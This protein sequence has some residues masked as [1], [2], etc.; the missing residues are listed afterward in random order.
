MLIQYYP[1]IY[2][3]SRGLDYNLWLSPPNVSQTAVDICRRSMADDLYGSSNKPKRV[4]VKTSEFLLWGVCLNNSFMT[5]LDPYYYT[6]AFDRPI[7]GF[8]GAYIPLPLTDDADYPQSLPLDFDKGHPFTQNMLF[9]PFV[10]PYWTVNLQ[11]ELNK[12]APMQKL[13]LDDQL[14]QTDNDFSLSFPREGFYRALAS[15]NDESLNRIIQRLIRSKENVGIVTGVENQNQARDLA[16]LFNI[17]F[18]ERINLFE[19][20][21][22]EIEPK[23]KPAPEP[24]LKPELEREPESYDDNF[25]DNEFDDENIRGNYKRPISPGYGTPSLSSRPFRRK[26]F[27]SDAS[28]LDNEVDSSDR[29]SIFRDKCDG[30]D[31]T[32]ENLFACIVRFI[33]TLF[34]FLSF[35]SPVRSCLPN[36]LEDQD[37]E[38][39]PELQ[40]KQP[41]VSRR[42]VHKPDSSAPDKEPFVKGRRIISENRNPSFDNLPPSSNSETDY[43]VQD[44]ID[45]I[46][47]KDENDSNDL[48]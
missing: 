20:A 41:W 32:T 14:S 31:E 48:L 37:E 13:S 7:R 47:P 38:R 46:I 25:D 45:P 1:L 4:Y 12:N 35:F 34:S 2:T 10:Q 5:A 3:A 27:D 24:E 30:S 21:D 29:L 44:L 9:A 22:I 39:L 18:I 16:K 17:Q 15:R 11:S 6:D 42:G 19:D 43:S 28:Q 8:Y 40:R 33:R 26:P 23:P 36:E